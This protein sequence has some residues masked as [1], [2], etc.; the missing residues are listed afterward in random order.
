MNTP[1]SLGIALVVATPLRD[2]PRRRFTV[3]RRVAVGKG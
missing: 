1:S 3:S 2:V